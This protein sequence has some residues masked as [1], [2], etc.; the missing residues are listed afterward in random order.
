MGRVI[1][2]GDRRCS[3]VMGMS[4]RAEDRE[5]GTVGRA[6][7]DPARRAITHLVVEP[8]RRHGLARLVP[9]EL[10]DVDRDAVRLSCAFDAWQ[11]LPYAREVELVPPLA[12]WIGPGDG[13]GFSPAFVETSRAVLRECVPDGE[14]EIRHGEPIHAAD[15]TIGHIEG[16]VVDRGDR[17]VV[18]VLVGEG[19]LGHRKTV[20]VP[21]DD[22]ARVR[23]DG[24][25]VALT[26][27]AIR[28]LPGIG[29]PS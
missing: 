15:G 21:V 3:Y 27:H 16:I 6:V 9:I 20:A 5:I 12:P 26:K 4:V 14:I 13:A 2:T 8:E 11:D 24:V 25:H 19:H 17:R 18:D 1:D 29:G 7:L 22:C 28:D 23:H 10:A